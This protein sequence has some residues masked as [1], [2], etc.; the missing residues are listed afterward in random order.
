MGK[1]SKLPAEVSEKYNLKDIVA[2]L[3]D[4]PGFGQIDLQTISLEKADALVSS[5]FPYLVA[6]K[7][8]VQAADPE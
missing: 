3:Y 4:F 8:K 7:K 2:G 6:K 5:G 1:E